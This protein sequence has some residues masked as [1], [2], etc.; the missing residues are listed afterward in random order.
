MPYKIISF[1]DLAFE[2]RSHNPSFIINLLYNIVSC[3]CIEVAIRVGWILT[4][5]S[6]R[7]CNSFVIL[8]VTRN[9]NVE[10]KGGSLTGRRHVRKLL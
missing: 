6:Q 3:M 5:L 7:C 2:L 10:A 4:S 8:R 9:R 1:Y